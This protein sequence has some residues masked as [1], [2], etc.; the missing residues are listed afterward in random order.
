MNEQKRF[1]V[2]SQGDR[3]L[4]V[5]YVSANDHYV[6]RMVA[7][8]GRVSRLARTLPACEITMAT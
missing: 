7:R 3:V 8:D 2:T 1:G 5:R 4:I 6:V